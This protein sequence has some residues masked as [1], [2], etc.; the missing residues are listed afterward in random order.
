MLIKKEVKEKVERLKME[1]SID[2]DH[3]VVIQLKEKRGRR[4]GR[5]KDHIEK[6]GIK[7]EKI[8]RRELGRSNER[9]R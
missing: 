3:P 1:D 9:E 5:K 6:Y 4:T 8:F 7:K 2:S